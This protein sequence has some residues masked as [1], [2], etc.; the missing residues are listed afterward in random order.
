MAQFRIANLMVD[1][2]S[3]VGWKTLKVCKEATLQLCLAPTANCRMRS[4][5][6]CFMNTC[7][8]DT[9][10]VTCGITELACKG[11]SRLIPTVECG[12]TEYFVIP[13][14]E[15]I[16]HPESIDAVREQLNSLLTAAEERAKQPE[17]QPTAL[18]SDQVQ[19][20]KTELQAAV[21]ELDAMPKN[22]GPTG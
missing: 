11:N 4:I 9:C 8:H 16:R 2:G 18:T 7:G 19:I 14:D 5:Q 22:T 12:C 20:M 6:P 17:S 21:K 13:T 15:L 3:L 1:V 10:H